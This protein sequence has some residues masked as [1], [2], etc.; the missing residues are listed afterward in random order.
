[1]TQR[2]LGKPDSL[3]L[4]PGIPRVEGEWT[5]FCNVSSDLYMGV[6]AHTQ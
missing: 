1:M 3:S 6:V 5:D 4:I 2:L